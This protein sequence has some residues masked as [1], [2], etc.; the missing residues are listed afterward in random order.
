MDVNALYEDRVKEL[1]TAVVVQACK[2]Y[3][4]AVEAHRKDESR[5]ILKW[6]E[7]GNLFTD[8]AMPDYDAELFTTRLKAYGKKSRKTKRAKA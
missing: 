3:K 4:K 2:D 5:S 7:G 6:F 1:C 8:I